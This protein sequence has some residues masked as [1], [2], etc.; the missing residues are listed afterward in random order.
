MPLDGV[1]RAPRL[2]RPCRAPKRLARRFVR[3]RREPADFQASR[4]ARGISALARE[5]SK[6]VH[7]I[8]GCHTQGDVDLILEGV[9]RRFALFA[10]GD[11]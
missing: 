2:V 9:A 4:W 5:A 6:T 11:H 3:T 7:K 1:V 8:L 10:I